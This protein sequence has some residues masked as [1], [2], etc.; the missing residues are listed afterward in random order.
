SSCCGPPSVAAALSRLGGSP[1]TSSRPETVIFPNR[2]PSSREQEAMLTA[3]SDTG[4]EARLLASIVAPAA[5]GALVQKIEYYDFSPLLPGKLFREARS[6]KGLDLGEPMLIM[7]ST[8]L[9]LASG[10][11]ALDWAPLEEL[12]GH[13][14]VRWTGAN[15]NP[16]YFLNIRLQD[17]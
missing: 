8:K 13:G 15:P 11:A 1:F 17:A 6:A 16:L 3:S 7:Q 12:P 5:A 4:F 9:P 2:F 14:P 10:P